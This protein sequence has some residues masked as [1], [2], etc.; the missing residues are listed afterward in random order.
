MP[1]NLAIKNDYRL[2]CGLDK[3][4]KQTTCIIKGK[5]LTR[6]SIY[7]IKLAPTTAKLHQTTT[8]FNLAIISSQQNHREQ[9]RIQNHTWWPNPCDTIV[10]ITQLL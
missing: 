2:L 9:T 5:Q 4:L 7:I 10:R 3:F 8:R 6:S 1:S